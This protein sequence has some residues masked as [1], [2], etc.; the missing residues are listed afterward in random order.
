MGSYLLSCG[1]IQQRIVV[2]NKGDNIFIKLEIRQFWS[3][4]N[5]ERN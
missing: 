5:S 1:F 4:L 3:L 2:K